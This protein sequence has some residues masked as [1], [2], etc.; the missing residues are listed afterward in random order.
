MALLAQ[1]IDLV[2]GGVAAQ[3]PTATHMAAGMRVHATARDG[4]GCCEGASGYA[5]VDAG[6]TNVASV[7]LI[8]QDKLRIFL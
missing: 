1:Y 7:G 8:Q 3:Q 2:R 4:L 5:A 6:I